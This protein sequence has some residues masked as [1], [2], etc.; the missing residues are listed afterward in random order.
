MEETNILQHLLEIEDQAALLVDD[1]QAEADRRIKKA[2]E[3]YRLSYD[4]EYLAFMTELEAEYQKGLAVVKEEYDKS[5]SECRVDF[6]VM[7]RDNGAFSAF[8]FSLLVHGNGKATS[9]K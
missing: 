9:K 1:A 8:A 5:L 6:D 4:R 7:P 2:E 3:Q